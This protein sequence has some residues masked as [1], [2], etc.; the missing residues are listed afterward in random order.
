MHAPDG[1]LTAGAALGTGAISVASV[2]HAS[3]I[4]KR[5]LTDSQVPVAGMAAAFL[6]AAQMFNFPILAGTTGHLLGAALAAIILGPSVG[7]LV[8][9]IVVIVQALAFADGG[10]SALGYNVL[11]LAI[12]PGYGGYGVFR[13][14]RRVLPRSSGGVVAASGLASGLSVPMAA[15]ALSIQWLFG[16]SAPVAFDTVFG[17]MVGVHLAIGFG[18]ALITAV[19]VST[20]LATRSDLVYGASDLTL[21]ERLNE[22]RIPLRSFII[23][24]A[25]VAVLVATVISQFASP[26][27]D[28]LEKVAERLGIGPTS[29]ASPILESSLFS[30]Y[31]TSG[32]GNQSLSLAIAGLCGVLITLAV[33]IGFF[34]GISRSGPKAALAEAD[35]K[36]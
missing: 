8:A 14:L 4:A 21:T 23:G 20:V 33:G 34:A 27:P 15:M 2:G 5:Q 3:R 26:D 10:L 11:N 1:F 25:L 6:F 7:V 30:D 28:G 13:M 32:V 19:I 12:V 17:S 36:R 16:A 35:T 24:G 9:A 29:T 22:V 31:A 18:E